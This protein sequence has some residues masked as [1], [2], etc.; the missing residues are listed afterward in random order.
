MGFSAKLNAALCAA[1]LI[2][3]FCG[4]GWCDSVTLTQ[5]VSAQMAPSAKVAVPASVQLTTSGA[6]FQPFSGTLTLSYRVRTSLAGGG[7]IGL[8][9]VSDF[10]PEGGPSAASGALKY[11]CVG[12]TL[13]SP[14][15]GMQTA[16]STSQTPVVVLPP[17]ACT[18]GGGACSATDPNSIQVNFSLDNDSS[19]VTGSYSAQVMF[20]ISAI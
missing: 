12:A 7:T 8:Q 5:S 1:G 13:G 18:G 20:V 9:V 19:T 15:S 6:A 11:T 3:G 2:A 17:S 10:S 4:T 14:C 16:G